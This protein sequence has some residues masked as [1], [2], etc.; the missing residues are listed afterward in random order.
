ME[1]STWPIKTK[2]AN[3]LARTWQEYSIFLFFQSSLLPKSL[4]SKLE[5][6]TCLLP[7]PSA[8]SKSPELISQE[9]FLTDFTNTLVW[10]QK[11]DPFPLLNLKARQFR[12]KE[13]WTIIH[14]EWKETWNNAKYW[15]LYIDLWIAPF[16]TIKDQ[17]Y[18]QLLYDLKS[19]EL[20]QLWSYSVSTRSIITCQ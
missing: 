12:F 11:V 8:H 10:P 19:S 15:F 20:M 9:F 7:K 5:S 3:V 1:L 13:C 16:F 14:K 6:I 17:Y 18:L 2:K 4:H